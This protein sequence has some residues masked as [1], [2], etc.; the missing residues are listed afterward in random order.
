VVSSE[1]TMIAI[2]SVLADRADEFEQWLRSIVVPASNRLRPESRGRWRVLRASE[3]DDGVVVFAFVFEGGEPDDWELE[4]ILVEALGQDGA[5]DA[6]A[7]FAGML[8][9][10]QQSWAFTEVP[11]DGV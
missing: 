7:T 9:G 6:L 10:G 3:A 1:P 5:N 8:K 2:N 4:P 11:L